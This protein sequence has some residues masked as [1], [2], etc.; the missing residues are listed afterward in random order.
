MWVLLGSLFDS[1]LRCITSMHNRQC[2]ISVVHPKLITL[3]F[4][5]AEEGRLLEDVDYSAEETETNG[6]VSL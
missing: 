6:F 4:V 1:I 2:I 3:D 5:S